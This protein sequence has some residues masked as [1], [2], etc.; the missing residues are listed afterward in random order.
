M[1]T[2]SDETQVTELTIQRISDGMRLIID[3]SN[4]CRLKVGDIQYTIKGGDRDYTWNV[5]GL[6]EVLREI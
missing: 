6:W 5:T 1:K 4:A 3:R 2:Q